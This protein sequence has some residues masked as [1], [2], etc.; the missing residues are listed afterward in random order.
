MPSINVIGILDALTGR[1][2][3]EVGAAR[4]PEKKMTDFPITLPCL[5]PRERTIFFG[6]K[7]CT[8]SW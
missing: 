1:E 2:N 8:V 4:L 3:A 7:T 5:P 6:E